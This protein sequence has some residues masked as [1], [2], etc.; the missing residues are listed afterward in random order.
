VPK[1]YTR[2]T[3][4][5]ACV[6]KYWQTQR[7]TESWLYRTKHPLFPPFSAGGRYWARFKISARDKADCAARSPLMKLS[8]VHMY[9]QSP[10]LP[11]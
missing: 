10:Y 11:Q 9:P 3:A 7:T 4:K 5:G 8:S 2:A 1:K 6:Y